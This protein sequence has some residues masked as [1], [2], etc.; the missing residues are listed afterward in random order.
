M[1]ANTERPAITAAVERRPGM[2]FV[3][4]AG[5]EASLAKLDEDTLVIAHP[6]IPPQILRQQSDG[7]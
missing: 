4:A 3:A 6:E 2:A 1:S 7:D 5:G